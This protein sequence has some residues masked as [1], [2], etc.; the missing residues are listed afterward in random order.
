MCVCL[1][2]V[3]LIPYECLCWSN[4]GEHTKRPSPAICLINFRS[5]CFPKFSQF[6]FYLWPFEFIVWIADR[7]LYSF[8][9]RHWK[10]Q[11]RKFHCAQFTRIDIVDIRMGH[12][13]CKQIFQIRTHNYGRPGFLCSFCFFIAFFFSRNL[14]SELR[15]V[16]H[17]TEKSTQYSYL[18]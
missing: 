15:F 11:T 4:F 1:F 14:N 7:Y 5:I 17:W 8:L 16:L 6:L 10:V 12:H 3:H 2:C 9:L 18:I 13:R